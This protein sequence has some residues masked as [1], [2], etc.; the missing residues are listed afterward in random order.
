MDMSPYGRYRQASFTL[1][2]IQYHTITTGK[3]PPGYAEVDVK[4]NDNGQEFDTVLVAG[5]VGSRV[6][7]SGDTRLSATGKRDT[8][9]PVPGW[10]MFTT[11]EVPKDELFYI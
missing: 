5:L 11:K 1:D 3:I 4:L 9:R 6:S 10:W 2:G 8:M 7:S